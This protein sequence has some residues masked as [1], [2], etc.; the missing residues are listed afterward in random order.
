M[1]GEKKEENEYWVESQND[2]SQSHILFGATFGKVTMVVRLICL[3]Y[4]LSVTCKMQAF[5]QQLIKF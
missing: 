3:N 4:F 1:L 2:I 5:A